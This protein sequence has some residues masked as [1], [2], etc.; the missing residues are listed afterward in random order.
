M[1]TLG[2]WMIVALVAATGCGGVVI[3][4]SNNDDEVATDGS[5]EPITPDDPPPPPPSPPSPPSDPPSPPPDPPPPPA[6]ACPN[7]PFGIKELYCTKPGGDEWFVNMTNPTVNLG[8]FNPKSSITRNSDGSWKVTDTQVRMNV[9]TAEGYKASLITTYNQSQLATKGYMQSSNDWTNVEMTGYVRVNNPGSGDD[10]LSWFARGGYHGNTAGDD[11]TGCEGTSYRGNV[12]FSGATTIAKKHW[13]PSGYAYTAR[14]PA[15]A[16]S[17]V[18]KWVGIKTVIYN[19]G[20]TSVVE[21]YADWNAN[22]T[23]VKVDENIDATGFGVEGTHCM[24]A[25]DGRISWG[26]PIATFAWDS[27]TNVD[28]K[29]LSVREIAPPE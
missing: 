15:Q 23:W 8:R 7:D 1:G 9:F 10:N 24:G 5:V 16:G 11:G 22:N 25:A 14:K 27:A 17:L 29:N 19:R 18:G 28:F 12:H 26:G 2:R 20:N 3:D 4:A 21:V 6:A 13:H